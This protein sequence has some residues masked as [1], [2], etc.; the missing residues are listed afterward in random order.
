MRLN[1]ELAEAF[2]QEIREGL[3]IQYACDLLKVGRGLYTRWMELGQAEAESEEPDQE[4]PYFRFYVAIKKAYAEFLKEA[5]NT[6]RSGRNGWQGTAWWLERTNKDFMPKQQIQ[7]DDDGKVTVVIGG[8]PKDM[9]PV[10]AGKT[11]QKA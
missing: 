2:A 11:G 4:N 5:K 6:I 8:K 7:A 10:A 3:P 9:K 1:D